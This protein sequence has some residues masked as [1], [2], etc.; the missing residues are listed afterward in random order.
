MEFAGCLYENPTPDGG[1]REWMVDPTTGQSYPFDL[2]VSEI[3]NMAI[4]G[5]P[6]KIEHTEK[7]FETGDEVGRV[8]D[9][10]VD[11]NTGYTACKFELHDTVAG[12]TIRRMI[13]SKSIDS[14]SLGHLYHHDH[15]T[16]EAQEV[17]ICFKGARSGTRLFKQL[18]DF[19]ALKAKTVEIS[20]T[21]RTMDAS[22][23]P[24]A[25]TPAA[26]EMA[27]VAPQADDG[28]LSSLGITDLLAKCTEGRDDALATALY[29]RVADIASQLGASNKAGE[30]QQASIAELTTMK[31]KLEKEKESA[32]EMNSKKAK[33]CVSVMNALMAEYVGEST[34]S[35]SDSGDDAALLEA[36]HRIPVLASALASRKMVNTLVSSN[37]AMR[38]SL[39]KQ[40]KSALQPAMPAV[41]QNNEGYG[42]ASHAPQAVLASAHHTTQHEP[43][44]KRSRF[45]RLTE[46][47]QRALSNIGDYSTNG[48]RPM[49]KDMFSENF[50]GRVYFNSIISTTTIHSHYFF[51]L[52]L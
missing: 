9:A 6:I 19:D 2:T 15:K 18:D 32:S 17:S 22:A 42:A 21:S 20:A 51:K 38:Q 29:S 36:A 37:E 45:S 49:T 44:A 33:E 7:G 14:L 12:R 46:G 34:N 23:T 5:V 25:L 24:D 27:A 31:A 41:W 48:D 16:M 47:Q 8:V 50:K 4:V 39:E 3:S 13:D 52:F 30:E 1:K 28:S 40:I 43:P 26:A 11:P 10:C 35:I